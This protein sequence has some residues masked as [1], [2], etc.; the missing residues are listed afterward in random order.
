MKRIIKLALLCISPICIALYSECPTEA[1]APIV[2]PECSKV[3]SPTPIPT[4][5]PSPKP[6]RTPSPTPSPTPTPILPSQ[7]D[8]EMVAKTISGEAPGCTVT[9]K[10]AVA[11]CILNRVDSEDFP[12]T[13]EEVVTQYKQ[14]QGYRETNRPTR[15]E[16]D[17]AFDIIL[18][19]MNGS[20]NR[21]LPK[22]FLFFHSSKKGYNIFTTDHLKGEVWSGNMD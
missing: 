1:L 12:N 11:W 18:D 16:L 3:S 4:R 15:E 5:T 19:W 9:Q 6:T 13:I 2:T 20:E 14:F 7:D 8:V 22:R 17:L 21:I 10:A